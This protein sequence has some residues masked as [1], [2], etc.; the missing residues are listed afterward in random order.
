MVP[1]LH[2]HAPLL[3]DGRLPTASLLFHLRTSVRIERVDRSAPTIASTL[4]NRCCYG[5]DNYSPILVRL[6]DE[7]PGI[8]VLILEKLAGNK[9]SW[10]RRV[11]PQ[12][13]RSVVYENP[14]GR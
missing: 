7:I 11:R 5:L 14:D 9:K 10:L 2:D 4:D 6:G 1:N 8:A 3:A 12:H 13:D